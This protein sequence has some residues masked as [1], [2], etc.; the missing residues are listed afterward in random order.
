MQ[1]LGQITTLFTQPIDSATL[2][3][4]GLT[5]HA[6]DA[7]RVVAISAITSLPAN[8]RAKFI[9]CIAPFLQAGSAPHLD[10]YCTHHYSIGLGRRW[11]AARAIS[12][13]RALSVKNSSVSAPHV[14]TA[15]TGVA[16]IA[17]KVLP[18]L[19]IRAAAVA[20]VASCSVAQRKPLIEHIGAML[21]HEDYRD[22]EATVAAVTFF[23]VCS[24][25]ERKP[26]LHR[27]GQLPLDDCFDVRCAASAFLD[28]CTDEEQQQCRTHLV[29]RDA[30]MQRHINLSSAGAVAE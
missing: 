30:H 4:T 24:I 15:I 26:F 3:P 6:G 27:I 13:A 19:D 2:L 29:A 21:H 14:S 8:E 12:A 7:V 9:P 11:E 5:E 25:E 22:Y 10:W 20:F 16:M 1:F 23:S 18:C 17:V 28:E